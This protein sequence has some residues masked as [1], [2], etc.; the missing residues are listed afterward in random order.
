LNQA[1]WY[2]GF[3]EVAQS[4][5]IEAQIQLFVSAIPVC[6]HHLLAGNEQYFDRKFCYEMSSEDCRRYLEYQTKE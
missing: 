6:C 3:R 1:L 4:K 2:S 5:T